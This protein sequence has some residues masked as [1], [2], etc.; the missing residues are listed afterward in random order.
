[1]MNELKVKLEQLEML[2]K[3]SNHAEA[4]YEAHPEN[5][6]F[7]ATFDRA[8]KNEFSAYVECVKMVQ[9]ISGGK[10]DFMTA[11]KMVKTEREKLFEF[12][13]KYTLNSMCERCKCLGK[14]CNGT[15]CKVWTGCIYK[16]TT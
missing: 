11:K 10:I 6:E 4:D 3:I 15:T 9:K 13:D 16:E 12:L 2:E 14:S 8:Y 7:E 5:E 1:M